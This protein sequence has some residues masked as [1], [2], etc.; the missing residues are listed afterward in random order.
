MS[1]MTFAIDMNRFPDA[2]GSLADVII[3]KA[4]VV[5]FVASFFHLGR[6]CRLFGALQ[7]RLDVLFDALLVRVRFRS[8]WCRSE[9]GLMI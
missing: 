2:F 6:V 7:D 8:G 5:G 9:R 1:I 3:Y 4:M